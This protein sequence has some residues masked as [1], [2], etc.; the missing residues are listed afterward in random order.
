MAPNPSLF[1]SRSGPVVSLL[2][3]LEVVE[4][5]AVLVPPVVPLDILDV[6]VELVEFAD[7]YLYFL[8]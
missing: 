6:V 5:E 2:E 7:V 4:A 8:P 1:D 3:R